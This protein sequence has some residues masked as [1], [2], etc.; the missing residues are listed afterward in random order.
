MKIVENNT[1]ISWVAAFFSYTLGRVSKLHLSCVGDVVAIQCNCCDSVAFSRVKTK[2][3]LDGSLAAERAK[4]QFRWE[5]KC[6]WEL[7]TAGCICNVQLVGE[8][9]L[10]TVG[11]NG[12]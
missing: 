3:K 12:E 7:S 2:K 5:K 11:G 10:M 8:S 1:Q 9:N 6:I 4:D